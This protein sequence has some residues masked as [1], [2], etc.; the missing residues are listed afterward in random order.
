M[1]Y[2]KCMKSTFLIAVC[3]LACQVLFSQPVKESSPKTIKILSWNIYMMP[4]FLS[5]LNGPRARQ[6]GQLLANSKY[7]VIVFEEAFCPFARRAIRHQIGTQFSYEVG[8]ANRKLF[9]L[10][11]NSGLWILSRFPIVSSQSIIFKSH[12]G[13][14][15]LSRKGA[16]LVDLDVRGKRIQVAATHLQNAGGPAVRHK[17]CIEVYQRLLKPSE[18]E[19]VPQF[20]CGDFNIDKFTMVES[21]R[22]MLASLDAADGELLG[23]GCFSY[24]RLNN[25][26]QVE[27]GTG[28][29]LIDYILVRQNGDWINCI[30]RQIMPL[31]KKWH[32]RH[33][34]LSD[35]YAIEAEI[36]FTEFPSVVSSR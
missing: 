14:D 33:E 16:I 3:L 26:L 15:A 34:D 7:D 1:R 10:K 18:K 11:T 2:E 19:G 8:P 22:F 35:H 36:H 4:G 23:E 32:P 5:R 6:I 29:N 31:R 28:R 30:T 12:R 20:I 21:Y 24:D 17:Q 13:V 27:R 25:D 9:S